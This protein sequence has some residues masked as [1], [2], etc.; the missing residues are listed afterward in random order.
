VFWNLLVGAADERTE[1]HPRTAVTREAFQDHRDVSRVLDQ[2]PDRPR[3]QRS[4]ESKFNAIDSKGPIGIGVKM[5]GISMIALK[6]CFDLRQAEC[7]QR[8]SNSGFGPRIHDLWFRNTENCVRWLRETPEAVGG[9]S[10]W[11]HDGRARVRLGICPSRGRED[12]VLRL[13]ETLIEQDELDNEYNC[14][15]HR[16]T[17]CRLMFSRVL[18]D[19]KTCTPSLLGHL[20]SWPPLPSLRRFYCLGTHL[21]LLVQLIAPAVYL[22]VLAFSFLSHPL[23]PS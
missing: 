13:R 15:A 3:Q 11:A 1:P 12:C 18:A 10:I 9:A 4:W 19:V 22:L 5:R 2:V 20:S 7:D 16:N 14:F 21:F 17:C 6:G 23:F 8:T